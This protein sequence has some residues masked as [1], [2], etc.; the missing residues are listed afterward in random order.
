MRKPV[1][2]FLGKT[3]TGLLSYR[4]MIE[5]G[6]SAARHTLFSTHHHI[7]FSSTKDLAKYKHST[8]D[9]RANNKGA[10]QTAVIDRL[11]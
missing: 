9:D 2:K 7:P 10:D 6:I 11:I 8:V 3:Y 5:D 4:S 1:F